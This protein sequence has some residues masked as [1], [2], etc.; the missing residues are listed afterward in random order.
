MLA[1]SRNY[2]ELAGGPKAINL[3]SDRKSMLIVG[4][5]DHERII[6]VEKVV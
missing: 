2:L 1:Q 5:F 3:K 4:K 6:T